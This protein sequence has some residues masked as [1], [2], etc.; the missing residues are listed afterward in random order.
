MNKFHSLNKKLFLSLLITSLGMTP[1]PVNAQNSTASGSDTNTP[2]STSILEAIVRLFKVPENRLITRSGDVCTISP[3]NLGKKVIWNDRPLFIW[4]GKIPQSKINLYIS[5]VNFDYQ[6]DKQLLWSSTI[7][8]NTQTIAYA[9]E[10]LQP[11]FTYDWEMISDDKIY[12]P[13]FILMEES[14][15]KAIAQDL[16]KIEQDLQATNTTAEEIAIAKADYFVNRQLWSDAL[17]QLYIVDNS[18]LEL[19]QKIQ[20]I[21]QYLCL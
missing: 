9:G 18:S 12:R 4:Q 15:R 14:Q 13:T 10:K 7:E 17:Q 5:D 2:K 6:Q 20:D 21:E 1:N 16:L 3:G 8:S 19:Q 11:G